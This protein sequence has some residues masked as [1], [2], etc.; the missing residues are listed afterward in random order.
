LLAFKTIANILKA[1]GIEPAP[2]RSRKSDLFPMS[3][4]KFFP[5][6][7]IVV[8]IGRSPTCDLRHVCQ[9]W[10]LEVLSR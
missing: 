2:E 8:F 7:V 4:E 5:R 10:L 9:I 3:A 6:R 1:H